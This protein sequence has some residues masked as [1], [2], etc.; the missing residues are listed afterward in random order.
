MERKHQH[1]LNKTRSL[2]FQSNIPKAYWSYAVSHVVYL[3][4]R[5]PSTVLKGKTPYDLLYN[6]PPT[7]LDL[8]SF[9]CLCFASTLEGNRN[10][11]SARAKKGVFLGYKSGVKGYI[12]LDIHTREIFVS[13]NVI[14]YVNVFPYKNHSNVFGDSQDNF[15]YDDFLNEHV[16]VDMQDQIPY[17][18]NNNDDQTESSAPTKDEEVSNN[19]ESGQQNQNSVCS[20]SES[21]Q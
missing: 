12:I 21:G 6:I 17:E 5:L 2:L 8:K 19:G 1:I 10:K 15:H 4:N 20:H 7:Y 14:F 11:F 3:I 18:C 9:G 13:R 16:I